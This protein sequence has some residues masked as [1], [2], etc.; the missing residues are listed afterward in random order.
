MGEALKF[1]RLISADSHVQPEY[2]MWWK[3]LGQKFGDR[4]PRVVEEYRG[5]KGPFLYTGASNSPVSRIEA[6]EAEIEA[7]E[8]GFS[9]CG[10]NPEVR[11]KFQKQAGVDAEVLN[12]TWMLNILRNPDSEVRRA[13]AQVFN[14]F[15]I[16]FISYD[17]KRLIGVSVIPMDDMEWA[18]AE[19]KRTTA[20]GIRSPMINCQ[21]PVDCPPFRDASYDRFWGAAQDMG[22]PLTLHSFTGRVAPTPGALVDLMSEEEKGE[23]PRW[24]WESFS[25]IQPVLANDFIFGRIF[26]RFPG[27]KLVLSEWEM[28]WVPSFMG[29]M[30]QAQEIGPGLR[31]PKLDMKA[32][33]YVRDRCWHGF[34]DDVFA[35]FCVAQVGVDKVMWGSD[36]PHVRS[37]GLEA[38]NTANSLLST[39]PLEDAQKIV[40]DNAAELFGL[41]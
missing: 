32:S 17:P 16:D 11:V 12:A 4:T 19:L 3:A 5:L 24:W 29:R 27:L 26:D 2:D 21:A 30:D 35:Q 37:I 1:K 25:E 23:T 34:I 18:V 28:S 6:F 36:F 38:V 20:E 13:C 40:A 22:I 8:Q 10:Y 33:E 7:G 15:M 39:L 14:D 41:D 9:E 31:L